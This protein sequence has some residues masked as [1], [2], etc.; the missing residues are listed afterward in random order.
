MTKRSVRTGTV[1]LAATTLAGATTLA[2]AASAGAATSPP[3]QPAAVTY[4][5][6]TLNNDHDVTFN[7]LLGINN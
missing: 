5:F 3:S 1:A 7:Q 2:L 6:R 4:N